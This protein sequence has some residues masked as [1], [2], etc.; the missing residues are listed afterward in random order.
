MEEIWD[1][2]DAQIFLSC[3]LSAVLGLC[4]EGL[5]EN[6]DGLSLSLTLP[7]AEIKCGQTDC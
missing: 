1:C 6:S 4:R 2:W 5:G 3:R 7:W